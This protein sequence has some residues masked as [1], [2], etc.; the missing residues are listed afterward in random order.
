METHDPDPTSGET[1]PWTAFHDEFGELGRKIRETYRRVSDED[2][3][4][5]DEIRDA[6]GTLAGAWDQVAGSVSAALQDPE[7]RQRVKDAA[8]AFATAV[9]RTISDLGT[10]L[11]EEETWK[12]ASGLLDEE[13]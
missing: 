3:P 6:F 12:P 4:D 9:G 10:E 8:S 13:E 5:E 1:D 2:G 11:R 7:V